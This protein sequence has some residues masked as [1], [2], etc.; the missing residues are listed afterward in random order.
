M[1]VTMKEI[2]GVHGKYDEKVFC[3]YL[4]IYFNN[5]QPK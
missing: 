3:Y 5:E 2:T 1:V 4:T